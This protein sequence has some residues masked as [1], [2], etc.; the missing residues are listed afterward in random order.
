M[1]RITTPGAKIV[2]QAQGKVNTPS[3]LKGRQNKYQSCCYEFQEN[4]VC[5]KKR[6][7][8]LHFDLERVYP[9]RTGRHNNQRNYRDNQ[10]PR[11]RPSPRHKTNNLNRNTRSSNHNGQ[12]PS[13]RYNK[14]NVC[15]K[16]QNT[17]SCPYGNKRTFRHIQQYKHN[18]TNTN[19][20]NLTNDQMYSFLDE[21]RTL[22]DSV[23]TIVESHRHVSSTVAFTGYPPQTQ[24]PCQHV[25]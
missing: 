1:T 10:T 6:R 8:F 15:Y 20:M 24:Q 13:Q 14:Y 2:H 25:A 19:S 18:V 12:K 9:T 7:R 11:S 4:G 23:K 16:F 21:M 3:S 22:V 17:G 5:M